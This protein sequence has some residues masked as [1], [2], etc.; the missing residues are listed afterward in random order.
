MVQ[1]DWIVQLKSCHV[2]TGTLNSIL[3]VNTLSE[4]RL[5]KSNLNFV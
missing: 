4:T 3:T 5:W 1:W 2:K